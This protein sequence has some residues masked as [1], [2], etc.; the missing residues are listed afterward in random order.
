MVEDV[1]QK[2]KMLLPVHAIGVARHL[3]IGPMVKVIPRGTASG[4][5]K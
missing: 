4:R 3:I 5:I 2:L 1:H